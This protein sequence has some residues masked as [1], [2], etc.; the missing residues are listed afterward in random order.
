MTNTQFQS[1]LHLS[2]VLLLFF[3]NNA[4]AEV[5]TCGPKTITVEGGKLVRIKHEDGTVHS[6]GSVSRNWVYDGKSIKHNLLDNKIPCGTKP[7]T[8]EETVA[9]LSK[10]FSENPSLY[11]LNAKEGQAMTAYAARLMN[12]SSTC[13]LL[14]D[15][16]K[17][18]QRAGMYWIDC[19]DKSGTSRRHWISE[20]DLLQGQ[21]RE[22]VKPISESSAIELCNKELRARTTNPSTYDPAILTGT[23]SRTIVA[24]GRNVV[25]IR[26]SAKNSF[27]VEGDYLGK[28][29]LEGGRMLEVTV[30]EE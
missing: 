18:T 1:V 27:G 10:R 25:E 30:T 9:S 20:G 7:M 3:G 5:I 12:S 15:G 14:V 4:T 11:G 29:I 19:N 22:A 21:V 2:L 13:H 23:S 28:C 26:F 17:S 16:A 24:N 8:R 6:G